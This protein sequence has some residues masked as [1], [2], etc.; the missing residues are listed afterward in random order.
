MSRKS[1]IERETRETN[2]RLVL[3]IDGSGQ[4]DIKTGVPF[5]DHMLTLFTVHG[6]FDL[7]L[8]A[9]GD[10]EV[11][12]HHT[13]EDCGICLGKAFSQA[14]GD[15]SGLRRYG[16]CTV[17]MEEALACVHLDLCQRPFLFFDAAFPVSKVGDFDLELV[18]EFTRAL[19]VNGGMTLH[20]QVIRGKNAHHMA[21]ALFKALGR[22]LD[23]ATS[24]DPRI[25]GP[26]SSKGV[27]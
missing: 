12:G 8:S 22:A 6:F 2:I 18:E 17:P 5:F 11:D 24:I 19:V 21:E 15:F 23:A 4:A 25:S 13:V 3:D 20:A 14:L 26:L 9:S 27:I 1:K 16:S 10:V 7:E